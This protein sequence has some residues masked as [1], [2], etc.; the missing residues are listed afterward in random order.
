MLRYHWLLLSSLLCLF[1]NE[2]GSSGVSKPDPTKGAVTGIVLCA[3]TGKPARFAQVTLVAAPEEGS[4]SSAL[5]GAVTGLDGRFKIVNVAPGNYYAY[6]ELEGYLNLD[7][8]YDSTRLEEHASDREQ[9]L[10]IIDQLKDHLVEVTVEAHGTAEMFLQVER[11]AEIHGTVT[12]DDGNPAI[13]MHFLLFRKTEKNGWT[14]VGGPSSDNWSISEL[15]D[16]HGHFNL[17][18]LPGGEYTVCVSMP[19]GNPNAAPSVCLGNTYRKKDARSV[20]VQAGEVS[21]GADIEIPLSGLHTVAGTVSALADGH[22]L[23]DAAMRLLYADDREI[24]R[25]AKT[26]EDGSFSFSYVP[27]DKYILQVSGARDAEQ[28]ASET[29]SSNPDSAVAKPVAA[30]RYAE[31]ETPITVMGDIDDIQMQL[32]LTPPEKPATR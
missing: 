1:S 15:T 8:A 6:A 23:K 4:S 11:G 13:G 14:S 16:G 30:R 25:E 21:R 29:E 2:C 17:S 24:A 31:K 20:K 19:V 12:Y 9:T 27:E 32:I 5:E 26:V 22:A 7:R 28:K 18:N 3:D 10:N